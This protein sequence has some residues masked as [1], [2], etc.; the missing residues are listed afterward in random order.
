[1]SIEIYQLRTQAN[2]KKD[3]LH[4]NHMGT[5]IIYESG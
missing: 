3:D 5:R 4:Y 2:G 1:M